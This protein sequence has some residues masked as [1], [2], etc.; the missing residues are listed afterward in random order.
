MYNQIGFDGDDDLN[1]LGGFDS[2]YSLGFELGAGLGDRPR[3][4]AVVHPVEWS[5]GAGRRTSRRPPRPETQPTAGEA[6]YAVDRFPDYVPG[7]F[8]GRVHSPN[9]G[10]TATSAGLAGTEWRL[11]EFRSP[12]ESAGPVRPAPDEVHTLRF[13]PDGTLSAR[14]ACNRGSGRWS[15][16]PAVAR[17]TISLDV[18]AM[19]RA[20]CPPGAPIRW[21][22]DAAEIRNFVVENGRLHLNLAVDAGTYVWEPCSPPGTARGGAPAC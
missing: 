7:H 18:N 13:N 21:P 16:Q 1:L 11:V 2:D 4:E 14:V 9:A 5:R 3:P 6:S 17:G 15:A 10:G 20:A 8:P 19:T 12:E 22:R